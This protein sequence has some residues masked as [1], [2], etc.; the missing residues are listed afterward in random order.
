MKIKWLWKEISEIWPKKIATLE[1]LKV[2]SS[3]RYHLGTHFIRKV[4]FGIWGKYRTGPNRTGYRTGPV[5]P[6]SPVRFGPPLFQS[7]TYKKQNKNPQKTRLINQIKHL[8]FTIAVHFNNNRSHFHIH[9]DYGLGH[10][11]F[12]RNWLEAFQDNIQPAPPVISMTSSPGITMH[13]GTVISGY[14]VFKLWG[15]LSISFYN[16]RYISYLL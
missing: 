6:V 5:N 13:S 14:V 4:R 9:N 2:K 8:F 11:K 7:L 12:T 16:T 10:V 3:L 15:T 1:L